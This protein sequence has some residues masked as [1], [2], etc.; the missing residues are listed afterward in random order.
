MRL[1]CVIPSARSCL[2]LA[3]A[4]LAGAASGG[5]SP[6]EFSAFVR[7]ETE[8]WGRVIRTGGISLE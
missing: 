5:N 4:L 6:E 2:L 1:Y 7:S 3:C 8:K